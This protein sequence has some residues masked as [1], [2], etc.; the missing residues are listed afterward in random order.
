MITVYSLPGTHP[1]QIG[2]IP[3]FLSPHDKR[4]ARVQFHENY[5]HGGGWHPLKGFKHAGNY[6]LIYPGDASEGEVDEVYEPLA[7][8]RLHGETIVIYRYG[9]VGVFQKD[10]AFEVSRMD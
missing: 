1:D 10:G 4:P 7:L 3:G 8:M 9:W 6:V 2:A 5:Q